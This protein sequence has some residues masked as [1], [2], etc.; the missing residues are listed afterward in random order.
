MR[1][2]ERWF[3]TASVGNENLLAANFG[4]HEP[5]FR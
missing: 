4:H 3:V 5:P 2:E 1:K